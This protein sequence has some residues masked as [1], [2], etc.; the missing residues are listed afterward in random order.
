MRTLIRVY[1]SAEYYAV[2]LFK[3]IE[4][5]IATH[6]GYFVST[7]SSETNHEI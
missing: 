3:L 4:L 6:I 1:L 2:F 5:C 7:L